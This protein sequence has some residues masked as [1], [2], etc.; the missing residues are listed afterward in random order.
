MKPQAIRRD[1]WELRMIQSRRRARVASGLHWGDVGGVFA[2]SLWWLIFLAIVIGFAWG[3]DR[4][5]A[6]WA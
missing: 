1:P 3:A 6:T 5:A 4:V 2:V